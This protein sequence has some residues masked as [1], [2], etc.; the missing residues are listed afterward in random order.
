MIIILSMKETIKLGKYKNVQMA[1]YLDMGK[2]AIHYFGR[3]Y[4]V[5][6]IKVEC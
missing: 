2:L 1:H 3:I 4:S 6:A 5:R